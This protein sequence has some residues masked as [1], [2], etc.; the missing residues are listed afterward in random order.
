VERVPTVE[1]LAKLRLVCGMDDSE[2]V[3]RLESR[4]GIK[5]GPFLGSIDYLLITVLIGYY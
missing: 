3:W 5:E 2:L 1:E 4:D